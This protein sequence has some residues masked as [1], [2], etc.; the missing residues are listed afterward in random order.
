M[1]LE[2]DKATFEFIEN[3]S[4]ITRV[5]K[6]TY[7]EP[8]FGFRKYKDGKITMYH[9]DGNPEDVDIKLI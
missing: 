9:L 3:T 4:K 7:L 6:Q 1:I 5:G 8:A 2:I